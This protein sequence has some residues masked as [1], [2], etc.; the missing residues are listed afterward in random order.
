L[1]QWAQTLPDR[2]ALMPAVNKGNRMWIMTPVGFFSIVQK[3]GDGLQRQV[4]VRARVKADL[5]ALQAL[6]LPEMGPIKA[7]EGSD[8]AYRA[9][10]PQAAVARALASLVMDIAYDNFKNEVSRTQGYARARAYGEVWNALYPLQNPPAPAAPNAAATAAATATAATAVAA[11]SCQRHACALP[12]ANA[13]GGLVLDDQQRL[14]LREPAG[15][16]GGYVWTFAKGRP[17]PG[18]TPAQTA[19][20]EVAEETGV[21]AV[22]VGHLPYVYAGSTSTTAYAVMRDRGQHGAWDS[23]TAA[24]CWVSL[25]EAQQRIHQ[26]TEPTGRQRDLQ[27]LAD[28]RRWLQ[29]HSGVGGVAALS[30]GDWA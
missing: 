5:L 30:Q 12:Q 21:Q 18:E 9:T 13:Y 7:H 26:T 1:S 15:H 3:P 14:L 17:N 8:Y 11:A 2:L 25:D 6:A 22:V 29:D 20:R 23:E 28:L 16:F 19:L 27:V 24:I 4:T 10:A